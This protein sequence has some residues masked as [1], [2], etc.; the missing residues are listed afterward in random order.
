MKFFDDKFSDTAYRIKVLKLF[1][2]E[3]HEGY[4]KYKQN[5]LENDDSKNSSW[6]LLDPEF[7]VKLSANEFDIPMFVNAIP[8]IIDL[9]MA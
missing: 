7:A 5:K 6:Y 9:N 4:V 1:P 8:A 3:F 2:K